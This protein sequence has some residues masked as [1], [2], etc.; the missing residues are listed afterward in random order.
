ML[1]KDIQFVIDAESEELKKLSH[2]LD[3]RSVETLIEKIKDNEGNIFVSGCG[4]CESF[5]CSTWRIRCCR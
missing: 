5:G 1:E 2:Y 4:T 3:Y